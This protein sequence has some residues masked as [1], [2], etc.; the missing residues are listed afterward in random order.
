MLSSGS[1]IDGRDVPSPS[2]RTDGITKQV[3]AVAASAPAPASSNSAD[4]PPPPQQQQQ[5]PRMHRSKSADP[6]KFFRLPQTYTSSVPSENG[7]E[8]QT[9]DES[10][11]SKNGQSRHVRKKCSASTVAIPKEPKKSQRK[12]VID[13]FE[14][15]RVLGK[16]CAGERLCWEREESW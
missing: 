10:S 15:M 1:D 2:E 5:Q 3:E 14:M 4:L 12:V 7:T 6:H 13:D 9:G 16:G 8:P 11:S